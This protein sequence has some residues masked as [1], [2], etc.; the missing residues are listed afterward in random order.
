MSGDWFDALARRAADRDSTSRRSL[1]RDGAAG[2]IQR[3]PEPTALDGLAGR[4]TT[5]VSRRTSLKWAFGA[6]L[7]VAAAPVIH[8]ASANALFCGTESAGVCLTDSFIISLTDEVFKAEAFGQEVPIFGDLEAALVFY[9]AAEVLSDKQEGTC[10]APDSPCGTSCCTP[11]QT[12]CNCNG[13][14]CLVAGD[15]SSYC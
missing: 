3:L 13:G 11:E 4:V 9:E 14:F 1:I 15:C 2:A 8:V 7:G 10:Q 12:C 6:A 5:P